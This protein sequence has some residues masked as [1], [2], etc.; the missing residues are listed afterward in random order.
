[1]GADEERERG[2]GRRLGREEDV[3]KMFFSILVVNTNV[4]FNF[5]TCFQFPNSSRYKKFKIKQWDRGPTADDSVP[6]S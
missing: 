1:M 6:Q 2:V 4:F 3:N 5:T